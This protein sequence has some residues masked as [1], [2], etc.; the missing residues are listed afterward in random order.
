[1]STPLNEV[2]KYKA[3]WLSDIHLG[4]SGCQAD[5]LL[6]FLLKTDSDVLYLVGDIIDFWAMSRKF[7]WPADHNTVVQK[8]LKKARK[9]TKVIYIP[10]NH[11]ENL[12]EFCG[13]SFGNIE[14]HQKYFHQTVSG[15]YILC[16]HGDE[17][18]VITRY[19][20]WV[21]ILGDIG[22]NALLWLSTHMNK[23]RAY[24]GMGHWSLSAFVKQKVK[25][26]V[27]FIS[28]Y[29]TNV[30][31]DAKVKGVDGVLCGHIH[32]AE[33]TK[34][35]NL[36]YFNTG[37]TVES[38]TAIVETQDGEFQLLCFLS[39]EIEVIKTYRF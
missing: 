15:H 37:D 33:I 26:A 23:F 17:F 11:D 30:V 32:H 13:M 36:V 38:C 9:G 16:Q 7:R 28:E 8:V 4:T 14:L 22:Y 19:H 35:E 20:K 21:A 12:R 27:S 25:Q 18:D 2:T 29:E 24:Y 5:K 10:G 1:M 31:S 39:G 6:K 3:I 34:Y